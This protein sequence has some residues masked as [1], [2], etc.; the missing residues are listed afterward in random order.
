M[1]S[2]IP[3]MSIGALAIWVIAIAAIVAVVFIA[4]RAMGVT[5]PAW[6]IQ[7]MWVIIIAVV[8]IFAVKLLMG[9]T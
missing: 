2:V 7:V 6:V 4:T 5:I 3:P 9:I 1:L 8:C